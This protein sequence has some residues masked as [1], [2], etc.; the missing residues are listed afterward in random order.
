MPTLNLVGC[1]R[2]GKTLAHLWHARQ[3]LQIQDVLTTSVASAAQAVAFI[4]AGHAVPA[5][6]QMR[7]ADMWLVAVPDRQIATSADEMASVFA[8]QA[9]ATVFHCS[10]ALGASALAA[11]HER[12]WQV[13]SAHCILSFASPAAAVQQFAGTPCGIEGDAAAI[14]CLQPIYA[15]I[16]ASCF[17]LAA[18][19]KLLYHAAA[20]FATNFLPVLQAVAEDLWQSSGVPPELLPHLRASL[21]RNAVDNVLA[22]GATGALTGPAAR[23][24][25]ELVLRQGQAVAQWDPA[26]GAAYKALSELAMRLATDGTPRQR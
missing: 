2:V 13:A 23:G 4:G 14:T 8:N 25:S 5:L 26:V 1:G 18:D 6:A 11:L 7:P 20:V 24:D 17:V 15:A 12:G 21:L 9:P 22:L 10:G 16:G 19:N 3:V